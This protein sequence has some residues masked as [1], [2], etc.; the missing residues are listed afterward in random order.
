MWFLSGDAEKKEATSSG[1]IQ[2]LVKTR[3]QAYSFRPKRRASVHQDGDYLQVPPSAALIPLI[4]GRSLPPEAMAVKD[5]H[6]TPRIKSMPA[7]APYTRRARH[8]SFKL[9]WIK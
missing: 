8:R 5:P 3:Q 4:K 1:E 7:V 2:P 6:P 9:I